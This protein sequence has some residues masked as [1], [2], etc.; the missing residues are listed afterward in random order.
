ML[1]T[2]SSLM[3]PTQHSTGAA[4]CV[5]LNTQFPAP[6]VL[7]VRADVFEV[8]AH[9]PFRASTFKHS[10]LGLEMWPN[11][12][13]LP[14]LFQIYPG[15]VSSLHQG[16]QVLCRGGWY[17]PLFVVPAANSY[18]VNFFPWHT[19]QSALTSV[20]RIVHRRGE[21]DFVLLDRCKQTS[22]FCCC[23][24]NVSHAVQIHHFSSAAPWTSILRW[25]HSNEGLSYNFLYGFC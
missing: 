25:K 3:S 12:F 16:I 5:I 18:T 4:I 24:S 14:L 10:V 11:A 22:C 2:L 8:I 20:V 13:F 9:V 1:P 17:F 6:M 21:C 7:L 15:A 19:S 23:K